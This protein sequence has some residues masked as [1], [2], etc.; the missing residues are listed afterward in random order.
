MNPSLEDAWRQVSPY[1]DEVLELDGLARQRWLDELKARMPDAAALLSPWLAELERLKRSNFLGLDVAAAV[2][3][4]DL[5]GQRFGSYTLER[6]VGHGGM[7]TVWLA[8]RSD[9]R[10]EGEVAIK[11]LNVSLLGREG[12]ERFR[13]EGHLLAKLQHP[14]IARLLDA[15]VSNIGQPFLVLEYVHGQ[16]I[17]Q[18]C[19]SGRL[20]IRARIGLFLDVLDAISHAHSH[21]IIHR[22]L[23]PANIFVTSA[24][25]LKLLDF[26]IAKLISEDQIHEDLTQRG[27]A[28]RTLTYASPEQITGVDIST[29]SDVYSLGVLLYQLIT[30]VLPYFPKRDTLGALEEEILSAQPVAPS[31]VG[32]GDAQASGRST[33]VKKL[34][35]L[36]QGDLDAIVLTALK[37]APSERYA[38]AAAFAQD[39]EHSLGSEPILARGDSSW[40]RV[41]KFMARNRLPMIAAATSVIA[42]IAGLALALWQ[43]KVARAQATRAQEINHFIESV[44]QD[45][46]PTGSGA[47]GVRAVDL[48]LRARARV[49]EELRGRAPLESELLCTIGSSL[50]GLGA[51]LQAEQTFER[52][53]ASSGGTPTALA[54]LPAQCL[55]DYAD[56]LTM[57]G[58]Y[59]AA[60]AVLKILEAD[61]HLRPP[62]LAFGKTLET[63]S[64]WELNVNKTEDALR[65]A[66]RANDI[67]RRLTRPGSRDGLEAA[68]ALARVQF[69]ADENAGALATAE[70]A[71]NERTA[72]PTQGPHTKGLYLELRS[73]RARSLAAVGRRDEAAQEYASLLP[74]LSAAFGSDTQQ[75][76]VDLHEYSVIEQRRGELRHAIALEQQSLDA[77]KAGRSSDRGAASISLGLAIDFV[78]AQNVPAAL[79]WA[80]Q[81]RAAHDAIYG[82]DD[83][84]GPRY[85]AI[86]IFAQGL[87]GDPLAAVVELQHVIDRQRAINPRYLTR[88][89]WFLGSLYNRSGKYEEAAD[90]LKDAEQKALAAEA[91]QH[92]QL[93][94][95]RAELGRALLNQGK[96]DDAAVE[97]QAALSGEG[98]PHAMTPAQADALMGLARVLLVRKDAQGALQRAT[99]ASNFWQSFDPEN[100]A[101]K[102]AQNLVS[103]AQRARAR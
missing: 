29:A 10:F 66:R 3:A 99:A 65:D 69:V 53:T 73:L 88:L 5:A 52:I 94:V 1:L 79:R 17:N 70:Q 37:K 67:V 100:P 68:L 18:Y 28:P 12:E 83:P 74:E 2:P 81:A 71:L 33:T 103:V 75:I 26:G 82:A 93:P 95:I 72:N 102:D 42:L 78:L 61:S 7:G 85:E 43:A 91:D 64:T 89:L 51:S 44:F 48:L 84:E 4:V 20:D 90:A 96:F 50:Y 77:A 59:T 13:R 35:K 62:D 30:G 97:F 27:I 63:R 92:F 46:D 86:E 87:S 6:A 36:L 40:Y 98:V 57:T 54:K 34:R 38:T 45:A 21:L 22:D 32:F 47:E 14:N 58:K 39:L 56:L 9:G 19:D 55:N 31:R 24:G 25:V 15:G 16:P 60:D 8:R 23:K 101:R 41:R 76:S 11:L 80:M 49:E